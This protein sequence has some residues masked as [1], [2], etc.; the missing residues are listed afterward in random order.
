MKLIP[1]QRPHCD[2]CHNVFP[3][4]SLLDVLI[5]FRQS[6]YPWVHIIRLIFTRE[7]GRMINNTTNTCA[8]FSHA[9]LYTH[10]H[11]ISSM[12]SLK[13]DVFITNSSPQPNFD[14]PYENTPAFDIY[15]ARQRCLG[16]S[17]HYVK[18][19]NAPDSPIS[20]QRAGI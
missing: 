14:N 16:V 19:F 10:T 9:P 8:K 7:R 20:Q 18:M 1:N 13:R 6:Y 11:L 4:Q 12:I 2:I 3:P 15:S 17:A 5:Q